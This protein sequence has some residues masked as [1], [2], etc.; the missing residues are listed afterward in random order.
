MFHQVSHKENT[1]YAITEALREGFFSPLRIP[2]FHYSFCF[3]I[4]AIQ[5]ATL[6]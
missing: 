5:H 3:Q 1:E 4:T 6:V 2:S